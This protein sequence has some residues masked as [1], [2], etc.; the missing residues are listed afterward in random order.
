MMCMWLWSWRQFFKSLPFF[1]TL[2]SRPFCLI[3]SSTKIPLKKRNSVERWNVQNGGDSDYPSLAHNTKSL[4]QQRRHCSKP[5][6]DHFSR[7][8]NKIPLFYHLKVSNDR[9]MI[10]IPLFENN[11][12]MQRIN[13][14]RQRA[15]ITCGCNQAKSMPGAFRV[16]SSWRIYFLEAVPSVRRYVSRRRESFFRN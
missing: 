10:D 4:Q 1:V 9:K 6:I 5:G 8:S 13:K 7:S 11:I 2:K 16:A 12:C 3:S 14:I 15:V